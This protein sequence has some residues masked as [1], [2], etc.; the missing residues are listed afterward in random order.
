MPNDPLKA[1]MWIC[2]IGFALVSCAP[3]TRTPRLQV[4]AGSEIRGPVTLWGADGTVQLGIVSGDKI[5][6]GEHMDFY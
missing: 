3:V 1:S 2:L 6:F 4:D 5:C